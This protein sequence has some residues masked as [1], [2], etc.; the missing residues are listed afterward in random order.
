MPFSLKEKKVKKVK[1]SS[2]QMT[3]RIFHSSIQVRMVHSIP[4]KACATQVSASPFK[5]TFLW[6]IWR[7]RNL[8]QMCPPEVFLCEA[9]SFPFHPAQPRPLLY[10][11]SAPVVLDSPSLLPSV[12]RPPPQSHS[13]GKAPFSRHHSSISH[14]HLS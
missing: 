2:S 9:G 4:Q 3:Y 8:F 5:G 14:T 7:G 1:G 6:N 11:V 13:L 12:P 10:Q